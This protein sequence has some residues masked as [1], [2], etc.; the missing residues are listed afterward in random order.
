ML[1]EFWQRSRAR[2]RGILS[3]AGQIELAMERANPRQLSTI[4]RDEPHKLTA[5]LIFCALVIF[6][7]GMD[8]ILLHTP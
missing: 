1:T 7:I 3:E 6:L 5:V 2:Q 4:V 8:W